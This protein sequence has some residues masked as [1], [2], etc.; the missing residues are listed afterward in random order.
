M[1]N[2]LHD[3]LLKHNGTVAGSLGHSLAPWGEGPAGV[4]EARRA[5]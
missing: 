4:I 5:A 3:T 2:F 1:A